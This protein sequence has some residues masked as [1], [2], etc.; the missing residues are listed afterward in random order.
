M[1]Q[2]KFSLTEP[3][4]DFLANYQQ[5]GFRDK[6][7]MVRAALT[8]LQEKIELQKLQQSA[9]LYAEIYDEDEELQTLTE[10][11][12]LEWP[13][14]VRYNEEWSLTLIRIVFGL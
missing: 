13:E 8:H 12:F 11:A 9:N 14:C 2:A 7:D 10:A 6:S 3:L 4:L 5:Y 1:Q